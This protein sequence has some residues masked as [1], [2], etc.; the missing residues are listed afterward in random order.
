[1]RY[2]VLKKYKYIRGFDHDMPT[3]EKCKNGFTDLAKAA[4]AKAALESLEFRPDMVS[5]IL[6]KEIDEN[7]N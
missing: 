2:F 4:E 3:L 1:M 6:V 7:K 5:Y